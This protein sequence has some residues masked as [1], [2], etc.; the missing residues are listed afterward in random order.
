MSSSV[1]RDFLDSWDAGAWGEPA[2]SVSD[3]VSVLR[4]T[5]FRAGGSL[6]FDNQ[7]LLEIDDTT[8]QKKRLKPGD[9]LLERSGGGPLQPVGRVALFHGYEGRF[10]CGNFISRL[11]PKRD[12]IDPDYLMYRL[13]SLHWSGGTEPLQTATTGI[14]NLQMKA[15]LAQ[16]FQ[17]PELDKQR[18]IAVHLKAQLAAVEEARQAAQ[19]QLKELTALINSVLH[20]SLASVGTESTLIGEV[21]EEVKQGIGSGW[22]QYPVLGA[23]RAGLAAAKEP[24]GKAPERYKPVF[25]GTVFYNPMRIMIGSIAMVDEDDEPG[26]TSP[27]YVALKGRSGKVDSRWF[28]YWLRS[29]YGEQCITSLARGAVRER[30]LF[31]RLAEGS[32][33]LPPYSAQQIASKMLAEIRPMKT[34]IEAQLCEL[35]LLPARLLTQVFKEAEYA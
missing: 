17:V 30:M 24:V 15:Y 9:L 31:N 22:A 14:R 16:E 18:R 19:A 27:D 20:Q 8:F 26:I 5:N 33:N 13:L 3:A 23:T 32:I 7:A 11:V 21:L 35:E 28:Y 10:I 4:S 6:S 1:L 34:R 2:S 29:P 25:T 12:E